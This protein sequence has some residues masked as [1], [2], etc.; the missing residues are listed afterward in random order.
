MSNPATASEFQDALQ[1]HG[2]AD[3]STLA[4]YISQQDNLIQEAAEALPHV[5][6]Q[7]TYA[8]GYIRYPF[9]FIWYSSHSYS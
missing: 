5:F 4:E 2:Q 6:D 7:C 3:S 1:E 8:L 9:H